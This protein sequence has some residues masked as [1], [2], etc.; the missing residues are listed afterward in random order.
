MPRLDEVRIDGP[1]LAFTALVALG[2]GVLF[3]LLPALRASRSDAARGAEGGRRGTGSGAIGQGVRS[4]LVVAEVS[5]SL[6]LLVGAGLLMR[7][8]VRLQA[9][10]LGFDARGVAVAP[11]RL[12]EAAVSR[13]GEAWRRF[14]SDAIE[15]VRRIPGVT[16]VAAVNSAPFAGPNPGLTYTVRTAHVDPGSVRPTPT[17][18]S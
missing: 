1:V 12:P 17:I 3:G 18:A 15:H 13:L 10:D 6:V 4:A 11:I 14:Y 2:S 9:V 8:F 16:S 7:S 5:L